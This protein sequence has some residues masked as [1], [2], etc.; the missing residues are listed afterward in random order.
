MNLFHVYILVI[1]VASWKMYVV[2]TEPSLSLA[3]MCEGERGNS[4]D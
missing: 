1:I 4:H 3:I 2:A